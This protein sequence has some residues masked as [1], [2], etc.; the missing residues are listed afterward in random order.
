[1]KKKILF[2]LAVITIVMSSCSKKQDIQYMPFM[3]EEGANWSMISVDG[4]V[5][6]E[7]EFKSEPTVVMHDRFFVRNADG[8]WELYSANK[9]PQLVGKNVFEQAGA[10]IEDVAP[11]VAKGQPIQFIDKEGNVKFSL[12]NVNGQQIVECT[13]FS[14]GV[15][16]FKAGNYYG[17]INTSGKVI[18]NPEYVSINAANDGKIIAISKK[19]EKADRKKAKITVLSTDGSVI[20]EI[21]MRNFTKIGGQFYDGALMV[22]QEVNGDSR[23]GLVDEM[24]EFIVKP[25]S[26]IHEIEEISGDKFVFYDGDNYGVMDFKG[27]VVIRP[28]YKRLKFAGKDNLFW[29]VDDKDDANWRLIDKEEKSISNDEYESVLSFHGTSAA[30][31]ESEDNWI[32]VDD[33][34]VDKKVQTNI[35]NI[36]DNSFGD[37]VFYSQYVDVDALVKTFNIQKN[38]FLGL[39]TNMNVSNIVKAFGSLAD[40][41]YNSDASNY[42]YSTST[43]VS[44][45]ISR[46]GINVSASFDDYMASPIESMTTDYY[47]Y[48]YSQTVGY[49]FKN[50]TPN[51]FCLEINKVDLMQGRMSALTKAIIKR[52]KELGTVYKENA[53]AV[54]VKIGK[55]AY[56]VANTCQSV[57]V[58]FGNLDIANIDISIYKDVTEDSD[59]DISS[60]ISE[61]TDTAVV[62]SVW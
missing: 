60:S 18:V 24:G 42:E 7:N 31:K 48:T 41:D 25:T 53:N 55:Q 27:N 6:F 13:N 34:C 62:D 59:I 5:L 33:K 43:E 17:C 57:E 38:G 9:K 52:V 15:A 19:F 45:T 30:V 11:V 51:Q 10:F 39:N 47:G 22:E 14:D 8:K 2:L 16:V 56:F 46:I 50:I 12:G 4:N 21:S 54:I 37:Y 40:G 61:E 44:T 32:F 23:Q 29:A 36:D 3:E 35:Y 49:Q 26:K 58:V 20:S 28:K 1:M